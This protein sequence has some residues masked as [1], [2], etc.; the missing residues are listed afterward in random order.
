MEK[1]SRGLSKNIA[2]LEYIS[3]IAQ[4]L[5]EYLIINKAIPEM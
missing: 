5:I 4:I 1:S 3:R 2:E